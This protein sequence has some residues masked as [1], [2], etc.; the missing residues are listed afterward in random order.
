[1]LLAVYNTIMNYELFIDVFLVTF[2][3]IEHPAA[4]DFENI[5]LA[6]IK[7]NRIIE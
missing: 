2:S 1:M 3:D 4:Y 6:C 5:W 7:E